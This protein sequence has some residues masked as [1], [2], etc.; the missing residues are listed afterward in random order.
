M[1]VVVFGASGGVG[2]EAVR[3]LLDS[4]HAVR[5]FVR[6][7]ARLQLEHERLD[8]V[9]G[10]VLDRQSVEAAV[11][12]QDATLVVIGARRKTDKESIVSE[13]VANIVPALE[14][15]GARRLVFLSIMGVGDSRPNL[16]LMRHVLPRML[17][18]AYA[19]RELAEETIRRSGLDWVTVRAVR[20]VDSSATGRYRAGEDVRVGT[21]AKVSR[22]DVAEFMVSQLAD[23][24]HLNQ[25]PSIAA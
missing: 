13:G 15:A 16:G 1:N 7:P 25:A 10:D 17:K 19:H 21:F 4:G 12:G 8:V 18:E 24:I 22:A 2:L 20:L 11:A 6:D 9:V 23:D 3:R 5:A 14:R